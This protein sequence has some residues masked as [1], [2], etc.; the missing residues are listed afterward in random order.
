MFCMLI[1][2]VIISFK[3]PISNDLSCV[4]AFL[5]KKKRDST[6]GNCIH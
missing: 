5:Q 3:T 4:M 6:P 1:I 2:T